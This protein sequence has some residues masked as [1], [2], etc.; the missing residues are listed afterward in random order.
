L[1]TLLVLSFFLPLG[2]LHAEPNS[3]GPL[4]QPQAPLQFL[5]EAART[6]QG[7]YAN[8]ESVV[9]QE[10]IER[11]KGRASGRGKR[12]DTV[13][14]SVSFENGAEQYSN[15]QQERRVLPSLTSLEGAWSEGE[16]GTLLKQTQQILSSP[17]VSFESEEQ[18]GEYLTAVYNFDISIEDSP[19][20]LT[21]GGR[22]YVL[23]FHTKVW[24]AEPSGEILKIQRTANSIPSE[25]GIANIYWSVTLAP[26]D[27]SGGKRWILPEKADYKVVYRHT[28]KAEWNTMQFSSY[29]RY[30]SEAALRFE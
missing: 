5:A 10:Q 18:V 17:K 21:V 6:N 8:M 14:A 2:L 13:T 11:Y 12:V 19:W 22:H 7:L 23:P 20:D 16:F 15:I 30:G 25:L 27:V 1:R 29:H 24:V 9:C 3:F 26:V 28:Q 4:S